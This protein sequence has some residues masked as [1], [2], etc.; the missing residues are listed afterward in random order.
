MAQAGDHTGVTVCLFEGEGVK[1]FGDVMGRQHG[2]TGVKLSVGLA[3]WT[4]FVKE[5]E[6][7]RVTEVSSPLGCGDTGIKSLGVGIVLAKV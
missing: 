4:V 2:G 3:L 1:T 6:E 7:E 5:E